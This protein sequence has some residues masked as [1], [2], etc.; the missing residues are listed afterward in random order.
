MS[1]NQSTL[2]ASRVAD[3]IFPYF[4]NYLWKASMPRLI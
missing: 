3:S 2:T 1:L 4:T